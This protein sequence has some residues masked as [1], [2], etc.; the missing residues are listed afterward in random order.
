M[1]RWC[2]FFGRTPRNSEDGW[3]AQGRAVRVRNLRVDGELA[4]FV[5]ANTASFVDPSDSHAGICIAVPLCMATRSEQFRYAEERKHPNAKDARHPRTSRSGEPGK[6][7]NKHAERKAAVALEPRA[8]EGK[9]SRKSTRASANRA[10]SDQGMLIR[11]AVVSGSP[12]AR[13]KRATAQTRTRK[14]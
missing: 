7:K 12:K 14:S 10:R 3:N 1:Q 13:S 2:P 11:Q 8:S 6:H 9:A 5:R 4:Q